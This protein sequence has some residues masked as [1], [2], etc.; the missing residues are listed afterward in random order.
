MAK[1]VLTNVR[2]F[3]GPADLT[4]QSNKVDLADSMEEKN[5]TN[6]N[7]GGAMEVLAGLESVAFASEGQWNAGGTGY[8][9]DEMW[10]ARRQIEAHTVCPDTATVGVPAYFTKA[11]RLSSKLFDAVGEIMPWQLAAA[12]NWPLARGAVAWSP[13]TP[14]TAD[15]NG[16]GV[17]LGALAAG[18]KL[19]A[20]YHVLSISGGSSPTLG[21]TIQSGSSNVF[22]SPTTQLTFTTASAV[23]SE[24]IRTAGTSAITDTWFRAV[25]DITDGGVSASFLILVAFAIA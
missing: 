7:S 8:I 23:G 24:V 11:V 1:Q 19:Y 3:V 13:G 4:G 6:F 21:I 9:D 2:Y 22:G 20:S 12:G 15:A 25:A 16:T 18:Q 17:Q 5:A 14:V 10:A